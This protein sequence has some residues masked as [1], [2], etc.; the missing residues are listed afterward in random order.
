MNRI[1]T[2]NCKMTFQKEKLDENDFKTYC[3]MFS[4]DLKDFLDG[5]TLTTDFEFDIEYFGR[6][7]EHLDFIL[8]TYDKAALVEIDT[9]ELKFGRSIAQEFFCKMEQ[10]ENKFKGKNEDILL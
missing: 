10:L 8:S 3:K 7:N 5:D 9:K 1:E 6:V 4:V 2:M